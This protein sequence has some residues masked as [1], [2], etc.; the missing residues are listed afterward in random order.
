MNYEIINIRKK[1]LGITNAQLAEKTG[2]SLSAL[3][4][5]TTGKKLNP[6]L[7]TMQAIADVIGCTIDD[8]RDKPSHKKSVE[9]MRIAE[10]YDDL[11]P[12]GKELVDMAV[13]FAEKHFKQH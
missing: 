2:I 9:A 3:E 5:I 6:T 1:L 10:V 7:D 13:S 11:L 8:F 12:E 4:K